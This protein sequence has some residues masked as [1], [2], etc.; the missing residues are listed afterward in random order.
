MQFYQKS[1]VKITSP[2]SLV[3]FFSLTVQIIK[4]LSLGSVLQTFEIEVPV[5]AIK[6]LGFEA[7]FCFPK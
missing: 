1:Q 4:L 5:E 6:K 7:S 3:S 2:F